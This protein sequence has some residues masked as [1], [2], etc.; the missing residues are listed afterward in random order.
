MNVI[1]HQSAHSIPTANT[2]NTKTGYLGLP[3]QL[4]RICILNFFLLS[5][6]GLLLR[7]WPIFHI[8]YLIYKNV[9]HAHSHFAF[10]GWVTPVLAFLILRFFPELYTMTTYRHWRNSIVL[11]LLSSYGMLLTFPFQGYG[12]ASIIFSTLSIGAGFY[13]GIIIRLASRGQ[14]FLTSG[15]FLIAG[16]FYF[17]ISAIGPFATGPLV[18]TGNAGTTIYYNAIYFFLHFQYNG[19]FTFIVLA[20]L[21]KLIERNKTVNNGKVVFWLLNIACIPAYFLSV[22]WAKPHV[23]FYVIGGCAAL[24]QLIAAILLLNDIKGLGWNSPMLG[25]LFRIA[26]FAFIFKSVLQL[27]STFP[28]IADL[29]YQ[30]RNF[31]IAYL[32]LVLLGFISLF[33]IVFLLSSK[34]LPGSLLLYNGIRCF[35]FAFLST[36]LLLVLQAGGYLDFLPSL[37]YQ[38]LLFALSIFFP[39]GSVILLQTSYRIQDQ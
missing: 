16:F 18:A 6:I 34:I 31:I 24:I 26:I 37:I 22:L 3:Q 29:A 17:F 11:M 33:V 1:D 23:I 32:H 14:L 25:W 28:P 2:T 19:F 20:L 15:D 4:L 5:L 21:Y 7:A 13:L 10:G 36:E 30:N 9:L 12:A 27:L 8:P 35:G 39:A 38:R